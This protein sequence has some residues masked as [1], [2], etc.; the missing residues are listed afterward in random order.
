MAPERIA[1]QMQESVDR[2]KHDRTVPLY[3]QDQINE[4]RE[5]AKKQ[6]TPYWYDD[7]LE[8]YHTPGRVLYFM[9][10]RDP[11]HQI[12]AER[13]FAFVRA[14]K[15]K[16]PA[17]EQPSSSPGEKLLRAYDHVIQCCTDS[18]KIRAAAAG[19]E[20][21][22][23]PRDG[24]TVAR[25][26]ARSRERLAKE[27]GQ[28]RDAYVNELQ[29]HDIT[30]R[31]DALH[32]IAGL[33][34]IQNPYK[35]ERPP[36]TLNGSSSYPSPAPEQRSIAPVLSLPIA[37]TEFGRIS[38]FGRGERALGRYVLAQFFRELGVLD[39]QETLTQLESFAAGGKP[40]A[41]G[42]TRYRQRVG[43]SDTAVVEAWAKNVE[44]VK[45]I[46]RSNQWLQDFTLKLYP[47]AVLRTII[48]QLPQL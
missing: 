40:A 39:P 5:F 45:V 12:F 11:H 6:E 33:L 48:A 30:N 24:R 32:V 28:W 1:Q 44:G 3:R 15:D 8:L 27:I 37:P 31:D 36:W 38:V 29:R 16:A 18:E 7:V 35:R 34:G 46:Y 22:F 10:Q 19:G 17:S 23:S 43:L 47:Q 20:E 41:V 25:I 4:V 26:A 13:D 42:R 2:S 9:Q 21:R 14:Q